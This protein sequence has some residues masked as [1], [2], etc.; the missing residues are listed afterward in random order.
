MLTRGSDLSP[1]NK[2]RERYAKYYRF[3][4][5]RLFFNDENWLRNGT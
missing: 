2:Y 3:G 4:W 5:N 1:A